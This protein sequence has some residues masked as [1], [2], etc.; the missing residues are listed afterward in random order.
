M[1]PEWRGDENGMLKQDTPADEDWLALKK[2]GSAGMYIIVVGLSW[3]VKAQTTDDS[4]S[5]NVWSVVADL[6]WVFHQMKEIN[7]PAVGCQKRALDDVGEDSQPIKKYVILLCII[8]NVNIIYLQALSLN[9]L[10]YFNTHL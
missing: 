3:W 9:M 8:I 4:D 7:P 10:I 5:V 6:S 1:Q 2:G